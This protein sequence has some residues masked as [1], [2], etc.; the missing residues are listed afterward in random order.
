MWRRHRLPS[1]AFRAADQKPRGGGGSESGVAS[2]VAES[3]FRH[4]TCP[5]NCHD[6]CSLISEVVDGKIVSITGDMDHPITAG[7]PCVK[8]N[9]YIN[10]VNSPDRILYPMKRTGAKGEGKFERITWEEAYSAIAEKV[11][12]AVEKYG[13]QAV[14]PH[15]Y[16]GNLGFVNNYSAPHRF[17]YRLG[18]SKLARDICSS[19]GKAAES[20]TYG[21]DLGVDPE[22]YAKTSLFV[23]WGINEAATNVHA[24][25][26][27]K[28]MK[29]AGGK[30]VVV[31]P[32]LTPL[33]NFADLYIRP[34]P[35]T[36]AALALGIASFLIENNLHDAEYVAQF[37]IGFDELKSKAAEYPLDRVSQIT[38]V[39]IE[40][41]TELA[42]LYGNTKDSSI[43]RVG[44]GIQRNTNGGSMVRAILLLPALMGMVGKDDHSGFV[45]MNGGY[46]AADLAGNDGSSLDKKE[47]RTI[48]INQL[49]MA[50]TGKLD[51]TKE[52]PVAV[53]IAFNSNPVA[54]SSNT[55]L[56]RE[57][58]M[59]EDLFTV[60]SDIF[61]TDTVDY[62]DIVLPA[63]TFFE[64][65]DINHD[66]LGW[67]L[68]YNEPAIEPMG[69]CKSNIDTF[70]GLAKACGF[71][72]VMFNDSASD[73]IKS[74]IGEGK[75]YYEGITYERLQK[76]HWIKI[77]AG[78]PYGDKKFLTPSGKVEFFSEAIAKAGLDPVA[79]YVPTLESSDGSPELYAKY[80]LT[81]LTPSTKNL[82]NSQMH[83]V[84]QIAELMGEPTLFITPQ[85][86]SARGIADGDR[87]L[88]KND[89]GQVHLIA[90]VSEHCTAPGVVKAIKSPWPK[91]EAD[92][93]NI[94]ALTSDVLTDIGKNSTYH[95]NLVEVTKA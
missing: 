57:G 25:K 41:L 67:Y 42:S 30:L 50:L 75:G 19:A 27:I 37:T 36:D 55:D 44:Y 8:M 94:N 13:P 88:V 23:S 85:D 2:K 3:V 51:T 71:D 21:A 10:W 18:A 24:I 77:K 87:L 45:Y 15:S 17:F 66:Y 89:R 61:A 11:N 79:E 49:G 93:K 54:V 81:F 28:E 92:G 14:L 65:E 69:E 29:E 84:P 35:G 39:S 46:W 86:A 59:R 52:L 53:L 47:T 40:D 31:N 62:A 56:I 60:V 68:R 5:R 63:A 9:H 58:L 32:V 4:E 38:G 70:N 34:R 91:K 43:I 78:V 73:V 83:G 22:N 82:L 16:S 1:W 12:E 26:F 72:D 90:C 48:S 80:P 74:L 76:E 20:F 6:T 95:T 64:Y 7:A 33:A